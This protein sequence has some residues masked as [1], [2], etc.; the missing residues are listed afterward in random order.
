M[1]MRC[2]ASF[3][4]ETQ[5]QQNIIKQLWK[6]LCY[7]YKRKPQILIGGTS[8]LFTWFLLQAAGIW[9]WY[10]SPTLQVF[11]TKDVCFCFQLCLLQT[12]PS[13][14]E[15]S[16]EKE[17]DSPISL[18]KRT[19]FF[20]FPTSVRFLLGDKRS[21]FKPIMWKG[22]NLCW[23]KFSNVSALFTDLE[24]RML[25]VSNRKMLFCCCN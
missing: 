6:Q 24:V 16:C 11:W 23:L 5:R 12:F 7:N 8:R 20:F 18:G 21:P 10:Y 15:G 13:P 3:S 4:L 14:C 22:C 17:I 2:L 9:I 19:F 1:K 25:S